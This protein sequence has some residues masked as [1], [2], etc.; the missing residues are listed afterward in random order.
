MTDLS[1]AKKL[2]PYKPKNKVRFVRGLVV[3]WS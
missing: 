2:Q 1:V 3:R